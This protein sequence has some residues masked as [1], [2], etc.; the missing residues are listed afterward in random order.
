MTVLTDG[1]DSSVI[2]GSLIRFNLATLPFFL[3]LVYFLYV[4][5]QR[6]SYYS[7]QGE[8]DDEPLM[9]LMDIL[10]VFLSFHVLW[11]LFLA[12]LVFYIPKRRRFLGRYL[13]E[14]ESSMGDV[15]YDE[16]SRVSILGRCRVNYSD[17]GFAVYPHPEKM[18]IVRKRVRVYQTY[19]R[20]RTTILRLPNRPLSGQPK[21]EIEMDLSGMKRERDSTLKWMTIASVAWYL[22]TLAGAVFTQIQMKRS[23]AQ[24]FVVGN[25]NDQVGRRILILVAG[26]NI[27]I[28]FAF[29]FVRFLVWRNWMVNRGAILENEAD[30]RNSLPGGCLFS[31][32]SRDGS[33][34]AIPYSIMAEE[35]SYTGTLDPG[36]KNPVRTK[37]INPAA[38]FIT[39]L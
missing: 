23:I 4:V 33:E 11:T 2:T 17:Y 21:M 26:L 8:D 24:G 35:H 29:N 39:R 20:E 10:V 7:Q 30:A 9:C 36:S 5:V 34:D 28:C 6:P 27:P 32:P 31:A 38:A 12:Y 16:S 19:T 22:F 13:S 1:R 3:V 25:E 18:Q 14:G 15:I 37:S